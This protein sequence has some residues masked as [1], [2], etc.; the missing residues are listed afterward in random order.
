[1]SFQTDT[2]ELKFSQELIDRCNAWGIVWTQDLFNAF[3]SQI[4]TTPLNLFNKSECAVWTGPKET[5]TNPSGKGCQHGVFSYF[6]RNRGAHRLIYMMVY[7]IPQ[8]LPNVRPR[9]P[10]PCGAVNVKTKQPKKYDH[11]CKLIIR[12]R[13]KEINGNDFD[14]S[15]VNPLHM[16]LGT[17]AENQHDIR[18]HKT[19]KGGVAKGE[20]TQ[21]AT[22]SNEKAQ[23]VWEDIQQ[24][25]QQKKEGTRK[26]IGIKELASKYGISKH[27][28]VAMRRGR[29]WNVATDKPKEPHN[30]QRIARDEQKFQSTTTKRKDPDAIVHPPTK[31]VKL[32]PETAQQLLKDFSNGV[33]LKE[34]QQKYGV[35]TSTVRDVIFGRSFPTLDRS[36]VIIPHTQHIAKP[37]GSKLC[38]GPCGKTKSLEEFSWKSQTK[39]LLKPRCKLCIIMAKKKRSMQHS[40]QSV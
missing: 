3:V 2:I 32:T 22:M 8:D 27:T 34:L 39:K 35:A 20:K 26:N 11:C 25:D 37:V 38:T 13:C 23:Q 16:S 31:R 5:R 18:V 29:A 28:I 40:A 19:G 17:F 1:M 14:G 21:W 24:R 36:F 9:D 30:E 6:K 10:C 7:G 4:Q 15:C 12:H 33:Q